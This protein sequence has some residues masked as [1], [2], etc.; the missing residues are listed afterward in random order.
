MYLRLIGGSVEIYE[1][2]EAFYNDNRKLRLRNE[3]GKCSIIHMDEFVD[4][5]I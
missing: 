1:C 2:L 3:D 5:L 4:D